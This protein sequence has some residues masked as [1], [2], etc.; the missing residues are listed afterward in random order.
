MPDLGEVELY[1]EEARD[2]I[3][4]AEDVVH[5]L[6]RAGP[7]EGHRMMAMQGLAAIKHLNRMIELHRNRLAFEALPN[8]VAQP[9]PAKRTWLTAMRHRLFS[10][11]RPPGTRAG[12]YEPRQPFDGTGAA[13]D[14]AAFPG[15]PREGDP[16]HPLF[17]GLRPDFGGQRL[18]SQG[19]WEQC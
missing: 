16:G 10:A 12:L 11:G 19:G 8:A 5:Q 6:E 13:Q 9:L 3:A 14:G 4:R 17:A 18:S 15:G 1:C 2:L 7:C